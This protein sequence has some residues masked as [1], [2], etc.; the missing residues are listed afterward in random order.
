MAGQRLSRRDFLRMGALTTAGAALAACAPQVVEKTVTVLQTVE[1]PVQETVVVQPTAPPPGVAKVTVFTGFGTGTDAAQIEVHDSLVQEFNGDHPDIQMEW[2]TVPWGEH[3]AKYSTMLAAGMT[4]EMAGPIGVGGVAEFMGGWVD[5][6]P[7]IEADKYDMSDYF[8]LTQEIHTYATEGVLGLPL[9]VYP[10]VVFY[11]EDLFDAAGVDYPPHKFGESDWTYDKLFEISKLLTIDSSGNDANSPAF[12]WEDTTQWGWNGWDWMG[13]AEVATKWGGKPRGV[14]DDNRTAVM[15]SP[16]W[17]KGAQ[18][19]ADTTWKTHIWATGEQGGAFYDVAG[20]PFGSGMV[21]MWEIHSWMGWAYG[22][23]TESFNWDMGAVPMVAEV[24][25][26]IA[27]V[28]ADTYTMSK[29]AKNLD[30]AWQTMKWLFEPAQFDRLTKNYSCIPA[31]KTLA[32]TWVS[33]QQAQFPD[34]DFQVYLDSLDYIERPNHES[35]LPEYKRVSDARVKAWDLIR[36]GENLNVEEVL[37]SLNAEAQG[38]IDEYW[39]ANP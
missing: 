23:W 36:T 16:E 22:S 2:L 35:W 19:I 9:C 15:N 14:S 30:A 38:Y 1:V 27:V 39:A 5:L 24:G 10:S 28:D 20:D 33:G 7:F 18:A 29:T 4:P 37:A 25:K 3:V 21:G 12:K 6:S 32:A 34:V 17:V 26:P 8:G 31:R 13:L 11:N